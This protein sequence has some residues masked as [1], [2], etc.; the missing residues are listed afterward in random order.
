MKSKSTSLWL[1]VGL[2]FAVLLASW[3]V[4]FSIAS[5]NRMA[6]VPLEHKKPAPANA[7]AGNP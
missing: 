7:P 1:A 5:R 3:A 6:E 2:A 4:L